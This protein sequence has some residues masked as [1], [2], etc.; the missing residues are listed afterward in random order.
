MLA[1]G[2]GTTPHHGSSTLRRLTLEQTVSVVRRLAVAQD[3]Q[4]SQHASKMKNG[5]RSNLSGGGR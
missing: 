5:R 4:E 1:R 2:H 3:R